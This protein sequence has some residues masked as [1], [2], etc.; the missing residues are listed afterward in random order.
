MEPFESIDW[1]S[2]RNKVAEVDSYY[3]HPWIQDVVWWGLY[4]AESFLKDSS[5]RTWATKE[6]MKHIHYE[7]RPP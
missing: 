7:A 5:L 3:R 1:N 2:C 4:Q 6:A